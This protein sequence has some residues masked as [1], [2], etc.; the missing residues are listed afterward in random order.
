VNLCKKISCRKRTKYIIDSHKINWFLI[1]YYKSIEWIFIKEHINLKEILQC[2]KNGS[3]CKKSNV[4]K[5][6]NVEKNKLEKYFITYA[7]IYFKLL[8]EVKS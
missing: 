7:D 6:S 5:W 2:V 3:K 1:W 4:E 8:K